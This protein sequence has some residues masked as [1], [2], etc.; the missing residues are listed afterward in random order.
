M[1]MFK[2]VTLSTFAVG[3]LADRNASCPAPGNGIFDGNGNAPQTFSEGRDM[4]C[5]GPDFRGWICTVFTG[6][7]KNDDSDVHDDHATCAMFKNTCQDIADDNLPDFVSFSSLDNNIGVSGV[8]GIEVNARMCI[9]R[10]RIF[11][12][13]CKSSDDYQ[14]C[15]AK[16]NAK[17][18]QSS[19]ILFF[20]QEEV[21]NS[22]NPLRTFDNAFGVWEDV[23]TNDGSLR[24]VTP[25][26]YAETTGY[27]V[28]D[29]YYFC[30]AAE[31]YQ[32]L[33]GRC[34]NLCVEFGGVSQ[35]WCD[36][37]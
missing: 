9:L 6:Y 28:K 8:A 4:G 13:T 34:V 22:S 33:W 15:M 36:N 14:Y 23:E 11:S 18:L 25:L 3:A 17:W 29:T 32:Y 10:Q 31:G 16:E 35:F 1:T 37:F 5:W 19:A 12:N 7:E 21:I 20:K 27:E 2:N 24:F 26:S 30:N